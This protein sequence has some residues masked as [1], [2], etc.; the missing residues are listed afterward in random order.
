M[1]TSLEGKDLGACLGLTVA[2]KA[3][4]PHFMNVVEALKTTPAH[5]KTLLLGLVLCILRKCQQ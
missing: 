5:G 4:K 2:A 3:A 1:A